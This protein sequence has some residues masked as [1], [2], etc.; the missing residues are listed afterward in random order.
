VTDRP[1][2]GK[3]ELNAVLSRVSSQSEDSFENLFMA[4]H[5]YVCRSLSYFGV[6]SSGIEDLAQ[7][8]FLILHRRRDAFDATR[9]LRSWLFGIARRVAQTHRRGASRAERKLSVAPRPQPGP[10][11]D[12]LLART[13]EIEMVQRFIESLPDKLREVFVLTEIEGEAATTVATTLNLNVN[14]VYSRV[15][16]ARERFARA[17]SRY[18]AKEGRQRGPA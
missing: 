6:P 15:R 9:D 16:L 1:A 3:S 8:V 18:R 12:E 5:A 17:L 14:T 2:S 10:S 11:P 7:E 13:E 4:H